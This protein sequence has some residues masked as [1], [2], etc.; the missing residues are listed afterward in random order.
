LLFSH[1]NNKSNISSN[2][3]E[4]ASTLAIHGDKLNSTEENVYYFKLT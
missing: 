3:S 4:A 1:I 2:Q